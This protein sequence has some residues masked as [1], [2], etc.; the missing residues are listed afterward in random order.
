MYNIPYENSIT[1]TNSNSSQLLNMIITNLT[2]TSMHSVNK[3]KA[4]DSLDQGIY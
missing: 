1:V 4:D 3:E 2:I